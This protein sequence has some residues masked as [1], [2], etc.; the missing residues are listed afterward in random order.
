MIAGPPLVPGLPTTSSSERHGLLCVHELP[1][2][3]DMSTQYLLE[4]ADS[5]GV[6]TRTAA[7][8]W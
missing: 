6:L 2:P 8:F 5:L 3:P 7:G 4:V 1:E